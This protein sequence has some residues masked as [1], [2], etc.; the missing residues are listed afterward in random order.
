MQYPYYQRELAKAL[1]GPVLPFLNRKGV[2]IV[3]D[4]FLQYVPFVALLPAHDHELVMLPSASTLRALR[5]AAQRRALPAHKVVVI[6]DPTFEMDDERVTRSSSSLPRNKKP[7]ELTRALQHVLGKIYIPR[8]PQSHDE[9]QA[10]AATFGKKNVLLLEGFAA[11]RQTVLQ[12]IGQYAIIHIAT[13]G[14]L[15]TQHPEL[16]GLLLSM[17]GKNGKRQDGY[18]RLKHIY[19]LKLSADLVVLSACESALGKNLDSEGMIGLTRAFLYAG[20]SRIISTLW[21]VHDQATAELMKHFYVRLHKG[22]S[23][24]LALRGA[25]EDLKK[26][27]DWNS[28]YYWAAFVLQGEY[29][30]TNEKG[31]NQGIIK[32]IP[33]H[34]YEA[35]K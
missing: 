12:I 21:K 32:S 20:S 10:I 2:I 9:A 34:D 35:T 4:G 11:N 8:L 29:R 24:S 3:L 30:W 27:P 19:Q 26:S 22:E 15:D 7:A 6:A 5:D 18:V 31:H 33:R 16:S 28:P 17:F 13:H 1:L 23:P 14:L 25:Q